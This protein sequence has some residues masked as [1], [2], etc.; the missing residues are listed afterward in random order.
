[1]WTSSRHDSKNGVGIRKGKRRLILRAIAQPKKGRG[2]LGS[3]REVGRRF[4]RLQ[5]VGLYET[6]WTGTA[7][8]GGVE[9]WNSNA[10][11]TR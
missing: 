8:S 10:E 4:D 9:L 1:M 2:H 7:R 3:D 6:R 5:W 11:V